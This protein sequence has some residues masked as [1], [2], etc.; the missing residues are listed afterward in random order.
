METGFVRRTTDSIRGFVF[1]RS[2]YC[3]CCG[4]IIDQSRSYC[5]CDHC[6][7]HI[8]WNLDK[9]R[10]IEFGEVVSGRISDADGFSNTNGLPNVDPT[11]NAGARD[12]IK[13][14]KCADY[15]IY[16][17]SI[18]FALKYDGHKYISRTIAEIMKDR[19]LAEPGGI[20][21]SLIVPVPLHRK[22]E[23]ER[24]YNHA[25]LIAKHLVRELNEASELN[26]V[27]ELNEARELNEVREPS[28]LAAEQ[29]ENPTTINREKIIMADILVRTRETKPMKGL[30]P[31]E[32]DANIFNSIAVDERALARDGDGRQVN[33]N[34]VSRKNRDGIIP[35]N[36]NILL[37]DDFYTTGSTA[38]EC[39]RA[40]RAAG[41]S[42]E[43]NMLAFAAR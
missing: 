11:P 19:L 41:F 36:Q 37:I 15:G 21:F 17:R 38:K 5:L 29:K 16:E 42:G 28:K 31:E 8:K 43:I 32:R 10:I 23:A 27:R 25:E 14:L 24:G 30:G 7:T 39:A 12:R 40:L 20:R 35:G 26:A 13:M 9:P 33:G 34:Q 6:M 4:N 22:R 18:I 3:I 1:P 2:L